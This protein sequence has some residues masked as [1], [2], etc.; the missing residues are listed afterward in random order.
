[1]GSACKSKFDQFIIALSD[2][3]ES[4]ALSG[5]SERARGKHSEEGT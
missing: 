4:D 2:L 3:V 1:M 5:A